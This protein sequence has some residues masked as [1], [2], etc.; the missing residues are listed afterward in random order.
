[1]EGVMRTTSKNMQELQLAEEIVSVL[2]GGSFARICS[3]DR[4]TIRYS[5]R[6]E[7]M[8]LKEIVLSR[9]SLRKLIE[10]PARSVKVDYLR[11]DLERSSRRRD[12][13]QYPRQIR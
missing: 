1:M 5:V 8:K 4:A 12:A 13:Y 3:D 7:E 10:D 2:P 11:R 9:A 6:S